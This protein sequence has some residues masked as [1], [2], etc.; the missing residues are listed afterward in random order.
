MKQLPRTLYSKKYQN[1]RQSFKKNQAINRSLDQ[2]DFD[3]SFAYD[4]YDVFASPSILENDQD[5]KKKGIRRK[6]YLQEIKEEEKY[7]QMVQE[8]GHQKE[9]R[10][11]KIQ[12]MP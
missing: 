4:T 5:K 12:S 8:R 1:V 2:K 10:Q 6:D 3:N 11:K 9:W 7:K